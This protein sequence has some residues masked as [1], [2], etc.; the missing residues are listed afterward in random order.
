MDVSVLH[1]FSLRSSFVPL[2]FTGEV[3]NETVLINFLK[4]HNGH[5]MESVIRKCV[6][7]NQF[8]K[9]MLATFVKYILVALNSEIIC[10]FGSP[11]T[12][13]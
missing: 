2:D 3:F 13:K 6:N 12:Y 1:Y 7:N 4:F 9:R 5:S 8:T 10:R 11:N